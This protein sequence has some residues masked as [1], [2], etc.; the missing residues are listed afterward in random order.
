VKPA[1]DEGYIVS[2]IFSE[3]FSEKKLHGQKNS[4][5]EKFLCEKAGLKATVKAKS[6]TPD[7]LKALLAAMQDVAVP[8]PPTTQCLSPIGEELIRRGLDFVTKKYLPARL[9]EMEI[10]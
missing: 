1:F 8:A 2:G 10:I 3:I 4:G 7:Q 9:S 6:S 5:Q